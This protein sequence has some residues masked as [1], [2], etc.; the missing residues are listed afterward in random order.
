MKILIAEDEPVS[1]RTLETTLGKAGYDVV[2]CCDGQEAWNALQN[3][4]RPELAILDW[5]MPGI[6]GVEL[7]RR[8]HELPKTTAAYIIILT[9]RGRAEDIFE[10]VGAGADDYITKPFDREELLTRV[11][12]GQ[13]LIEMQQ[14]GL[15][16][17]PEEIIR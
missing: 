4:D 7:C 2:F 17:A 9:A 12:V 15:D 8:I 1:R 14:K 13:Q 3:P 6:D 16:R 10:G 11:M 5:M